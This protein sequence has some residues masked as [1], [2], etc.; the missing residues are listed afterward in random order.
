[1]AK[2]EKQYKSELHITID[3][4]GM[5][6][7]SIVGE[8]ESNVDGFEFY[9]SIKDLIDQWNKQLKEYLNDINNKAPKSKNIRNN[10]K[11]NTSY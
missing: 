4:K 11:N 9:L 8:D 6:C 1:M 10:T 5:K 7:L 3:F 2:Q